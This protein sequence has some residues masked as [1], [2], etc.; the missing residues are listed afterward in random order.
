MAHQTGSQVPG[1]RHLPARQPVLRLHRRPEVPEGG[2]AFPRCG[3]DHWQILPGDP[4]HGPE[5]PQPLVAGTRRCTGLTEGV[6]APGRWAGHSAA[7]APQSPTAASPPR[8]PRLPVAGT[9][10]PTVFWGALRAI[11]QRERLMS[12]PLLFQDFKGS[13]NALTSGRRGRE[14]TPNNFFFSFLQRE[15]QMSNTYIPTYIN[16]FIWVNGP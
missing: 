10:H 4:A 14:A 7:P 13:R 9:P 8:L 12:F 16:R 15:T 2:Q 6:L 3:F 5:P 1:G 11:T